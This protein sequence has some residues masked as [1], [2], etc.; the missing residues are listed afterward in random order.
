MEPG[1]L[2]ARVRLG[3]ARLARDRPALLRARR[4]ARRPRARS[5]SR[6]PSSR[7]DLSISAAQWLADGRLVLVAVVRSATRVATSSAAPALCGS[8]TEPANAPSGPLGVRALTD[9]TT[10]DIEVEGGSA[11]LVVQGGRVVVQELHRGS[12][13][14]A[15][16]RPRRRCRPRCCS[17][18]RW[19]S[20]PTPRRTTGRRWSRSSS[21][22]DR[23]GDLAVVRD[24]QR[25]VADRRQRPPARG[26][27]APAGRGRGHLRRRPPGAR[28]GVPAR[29]RDVRRGPLP[30]AAQHPRRPVHAVRLGRLRRGPGVR[31]GRVRRGHV[32]PAR[33]R[34]LRRR[35]RPLDPARDGRRRRRRR[36]GLPRPRARRRR[37][38]AGRRPGRRHGR[39]L[40]RLHDR[41]ADHPH[42]AG[43]PARSSSAATSTP[44]RSSGPPTSAGSSP[45]S[46]TAPPDGM[47]DAEPAER[48]RQGQHA[49]AGDPLRVRL[50]HARSSR[51]SGG[52]RRCGRAAYAPSCCCSPPRATS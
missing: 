25:A 30:G 22:P 9:D 45:R 10:S 16:G 33:L 13:P 41:A 12:R 38:A 27:P 11:G 43:S 34:G 49:D 37:A 51:G 15:R 50:A 23:A 40:R 6:R 44:P 28:L 24:G 8:P 48:R 31:R 35:A 5:P 19:S 29:P 47:R 52:S 26:R 18:A 32:Q 2:A 20:P 39:L 7:G 21:T 36:A 14:P 1:R 3:A 4:G 42:R 46:T 17:T